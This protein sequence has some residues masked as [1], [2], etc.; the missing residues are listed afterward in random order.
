MGTIW[1]RGSSWYINYRVNGRR[2]KEKIGRSK[3]LAKQVLAKREVDI[4]EKKFF[5]QNRTSSITFAHAAEKWWRLHGQ[6][7]LSRSTR[8]P[9]DKVIAIFGNKRLREISVSE[10]Q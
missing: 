10:L 8:Y 7:L 9:V 5:P 2:Y 6:N 4:A 1:Q 3:T